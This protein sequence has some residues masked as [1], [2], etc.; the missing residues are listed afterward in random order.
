MGM[1]ERFRKQILKGIFPRGSRD[2]VFEKIMGC[3]GRQLTGD[4]ALAPA[5][6][7]R[8]QEDAP[9][10]VNEKGVVVFRVCS[11]L[12]GGIGCAHISLLSF[13][14][15]SIRFPAKTR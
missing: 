14:D 3:P 6:A 9:V 13:T 15:E 8:K 7:V 12:V 1:R 5:H 2:M 11:A 4:L 10:R